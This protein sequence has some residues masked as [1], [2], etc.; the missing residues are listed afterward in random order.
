MRNKV[1]GRRRLPWRALS[2]RHISLRH[3]YIS[4]GCGMR[5]P[6]EFRDFGFEFNGRRSAQQQLLDQSLQRRKLWLKFQALG[7]EGGLT[8]VHVPNLR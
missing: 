4:P 2:L 6:G 8:Q 1:V 5:L 7:W 3:S